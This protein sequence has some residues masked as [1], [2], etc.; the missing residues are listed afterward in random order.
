MKKWMAIL[1]VLVMVFA[2]LA[3]SDLSI[4]AVEKEYQYKGVFESYAKENGYKDFTY[5]EIGGGDYW[6]LVYAK[7]E[8]D[9]CDKLIKGTFGD[10]VIVNYDDKQ[11]FTFGYGVFWRRVGFVPLTDV[12]NNPYFVGLHEMFRNYTDGI[13]RNDDSTVWLLGDTDRDGRLTII[14]ATHIQKRLANLE[15]TPFYDS[16]PEVAAVKFGADIR[17]LSDM[18][19]DGEK[20]ILDATV[21]QKR[22]ASCLVDQNLEFKVLANDTAS[23]AAE[24][25]KGAQM[26]TSYD[27]L[28]EMREWFSEEV[29]NNAL[30][31]CDEAYFQERV[32]LMYTDI[33][34]STGY[35]RENFSVVKDKNYDIIFEHDMVYPSGGSAAVMTDR[36][37]LL[38]LNRKDIPECAG[39]NTIVYPKGAMGEEYL[40]YALT[41]NFNKNAVAISDN[42]INWKESFNGNAEESIENFNDT[43]RYGVMALLRSRAQYEA[44]MRD[45][46]DR[47]YVDMHPENPEDYG[48]ELEDI[49]D[50]AFFDK[51]SLVVTAY[52]YVGGNYT[53]KIIAAA[54]SES[55]LYVAIRTKNVPEEP[56]VAP[57]YSYNLSVN[58]VK[59][60]DV[61]HVRS[62]GL[63]L[64]RD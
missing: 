30:S 62:L 32:I 47:Q 3:V 20:S 61:S 10:R 29:W 19:R 16:I 52:R 22:L 14:D 12:W 26:I 38:S 35:K 6:T 50:D 21:I 27:Q 49:Y 43:D 59:K 46:G 56:H 11:P 42:D 5:D 48:T 23:P 31:F 40:S 28:V 45:Y 58:M 1:L 13:L 25:C 51:Y 55:R 8:G 17:F 53:A 63:L 39:I 34:S 24:Y 37:I 41:D 54:V 7:W 64:M 60:E 2:L 57:I 15:E 33:E 18:D 9:A 44:F 4:A 36:L